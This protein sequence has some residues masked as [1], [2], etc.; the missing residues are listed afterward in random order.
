MPQRTSGVLIIAGLI[1]AL[2]LGFIFSIVLLGSVEG[3]CASGSTLAGVTIDPDSVPDTAIAGYGHEQL[4]NAAYIIQAGHA[5]GLSARDQTIGVMTAMGES[6][7]TVID[8]GDTAGPDSRGLFQQRANGAWGSYEDRMDPY[9]SATNFFNA[10]IANVPDRDTPEP[11]IVAHRVQRNT[12]PYHYTRYWTA[13]VQVVEGLD[14]VQG[15]ANGDPLASSSQYALGEVQPQT[16][17]VANIVGPM[18]GIQTIGGYRESAHD[19]GGHPSGLATTTRDD[20]AEAGALLL[21]A[22]AQR[23]EHSARLANQAVAIV[24]QAD[25]K[26]PATDVAR[27]AAGYGTLARETATIPYDPAMVDGL[28]RYG[29]RTATGRQGA[30][31]L[32]RAR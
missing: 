6:S 5:L 30:R 7:L 25:S 19:P 20:H 8:Y 10:M 11:T 26:A 2:L 29:S 32:L 23:D 22:L 27:V 18:F 1:P 14:G 17:A 9:T 15:I 31:W 28:L 3:R 12:D 4:V 13:A 21:E 24:T 16:V